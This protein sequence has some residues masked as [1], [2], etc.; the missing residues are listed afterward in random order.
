[1]FIRNWAGHEP[2]QPSPTPSST[3]CL[4][5]GRP[6][7]IAGVLDEWLTNFIKAQ[8][9]RGHHEGAESIVRLHLRPR[10]GEIPI[11]GLTSRMIQLWVTEFGIR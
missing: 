1:M 5:D 4:P 3:I 7:T 2:Q 11:D 8:R 6:A 9:S 10:F